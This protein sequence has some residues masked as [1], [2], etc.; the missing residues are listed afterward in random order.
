MKLFPNDEIVS[1][2]SCP[3]TPNEE[4]F[5]NVPSFAYSALSLRYFVTN[6]G[7]RWS[8][9]VGYVFVKF[10]IIA[11]V[12][13]SGN[14]LTPIAWKFKKEG[15][16]ELSKGVSSKWDGIMRWLSGLFWCIRQTQLEVTFIGDEVLHGGE[17]SRSVE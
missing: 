14:V 4:K 10:R 16:P 3:L 1:A 13:D 11:N 12:E 7:D 17:L 2:L 8:E 5:R 15:A 6:E 9:W